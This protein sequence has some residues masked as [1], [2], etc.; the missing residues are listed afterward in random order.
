MESRWAVDL[1]GMQRAGMWDAVVL[2][3]RTALKEVGLCMTGWD[4]DEPGL[5]KKEA[6]R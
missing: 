6:E 5:W 1:Q 3:K 2:G 4:L